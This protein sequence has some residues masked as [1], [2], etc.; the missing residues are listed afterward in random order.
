MKRIRILAASVL[1]ASTPLIAAGC[2]NG[3][4][5]SAGAPVLH[6]VTG[7][8]AL[9]QAVGQIGQGRVSVLDVVPS[10]SDPKTYPLDP[11]EAG[12]VRA[13]QLV[14]DVGGGFQPS[15]EAAAQATR[16]LSVA[17]ALGATDQYPWLDPAQM[18]RAISAI[19]SA[20]EAADPQAAGLFRDGARAF[21][22]S[23]DSTG[24]D[25]QSTL[26]TCP[27]Q[28]IFTPDAAFSRMAADYGLK[29]TVL[30]AGTGGGSVQAAAAAVRAAGASTVFAETW[31]S[32]GAVDA[33]AGAA[34]AK[35][36][37]LDTLVGPPSGGYPPRADYF[38][39]MESDLGSLSAALGCPNTSTGND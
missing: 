36:R 29:D 16:V 32:S 24:I 15:F 3:S 20:M 17:S 22:A 14:V 38:S 30:G 21:A 1:L 35:V 10:G 7:V 13:A 12:E 11:A 4:A 31:V 9:A 26:S 18:R 19:A 5:S 28:M 37:T 34:G 6:V 23:L 2:R 8:Y 39:L 25:Y 33:V 27:R